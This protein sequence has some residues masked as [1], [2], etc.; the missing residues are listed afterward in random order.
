MTTEQT[1][2]HTPE[3][4][5]QALNDGFLAGFNAVAEGEPVKE[6]PAPE[7]K[8]EVAP[9]PE[10]DPE[11]LQAITKEEPEVTP[12]Q[13]QAILAKVSEFDSFRSA[14]DKLSGHVGTLLQEV[15]AIKEPPAK[16]T[17]QL[18]PVDEGEFA[19]AYPEFASYL[20]AQMSKVTLPAEVQAKIDAAE[21]KAAELEA[22]LEER[23][24]GLMH[25]DWKDVVGSNQ[26]KAW[27]LTQPEDVQNVAKN[28]PYAVDLDRVIR[29][30]KETAQKAQTA[31]KNKERLEAAV[32]PS[33]VPAQRPPEPS[34]QDAFRNGW[35]AVRRRA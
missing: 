14:F 23:T 18:P 16:P 21:A 30:Y 25:P 6:E 35:D 1:P 3:Q 32:V 5:E 24:I 8:E 27:L 17:L 11:V 31:A 19:Q 34:E 13:F 22:R 2:E 28:S 15:K 9:E 20:Q 26:Y 33:G 4:L 12:D 10:V 7:P 29:S